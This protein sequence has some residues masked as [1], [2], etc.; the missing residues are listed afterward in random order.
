MRQT[1]QTL[2]LTKTTVHKYSSHYTDAGIESW[3]PDAT[4]RPESC[5]LTSVMDVQSAPHCCRSSDLEPRL[6]SSSPGMVHFIGTESIH[7]SPSSPRPRFSL[8]I[9]KEV[10]HVK[11]KDWKCQEHLTAISRKKKQV[12][13]NFLTLLALYLSCWW[14][15]AGHGSRSSYFCQPLH[16][17][18]C[19]GRWS[20]DESHG[21]YWLSAL[22]GLTACPPPLLLPH[23]TG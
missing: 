17:P 6:K 3:F 13:D 8:Y 1:S 12:I 7:F 14:R 16:G 19:K 4:D 2:N 22:G 5:G 15:A 21:D 18:S 11:E 9:L 20:I 23:L 10:I